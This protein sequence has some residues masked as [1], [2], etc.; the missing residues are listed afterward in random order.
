MSQ[1]CA[2]RVLVSQF[3]GRGL[4]LGAFALIAC[5]G[6]SD[7]SIDGWACA[8]KDVPLGHT[9]ECTLKVASALYA[10]APAYYCSDHVADTKCPDRNAWVR[11]QAAQTSATGSSDGVSN[12]GAASS[13]SIANPGASSAVNGSG[14]I[15]LAGFYCT[16]E[17]DA[18]KCRREPVCDAGAHRVQMDCE[19]DAS[20]A[21]GDGGGT[22]SH[23]AGGDSE[24]GL[25]GAQTQ[26]FYAAGATPGSSVPAATFQYVLEAIAGVQQ[27]HV[28]LT[29]SP[30]F[31]DNSYG[32]SSVGWSSKGHKFTELVGS[33]HAELSFVDTAAQEKLH[34]KMDYISRSATAPSGYA[35]LGVTGGEGRMLLGD[36]SMITKVSSSLDRNLNERGYSTF[37][38]DSPATDANYATPTSAPKWDFNVVY[39][40]WI[41]N[42]AFGGKGFGSVQ[43]SFVHASP[44]KAG[45]N[46]LPVT[47]GPCPP[48]W[49]G[50][51]AV[52][53]GSQS[54]IR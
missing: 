17:L 40:A 11:F 26:C 14:G 41:K 31:V 33:D 5:S 23:Y 39:E 7:T 36:A 21:L 44:S 18:I 10:Q 28:R 12:P 32:A 42:E 19:P 51:S 47:Q 48:S 43:L 1:R 35:C 9:V 24:D 4:W 37:V 54:G 16:H 53:D 45:T 30:M 2:D 52:T 8:N 38:L 6:S 15:G 34:F 46:T 20:I 49:M 22:G 3:V 25:P 13:D 50:A 29:F 27:L